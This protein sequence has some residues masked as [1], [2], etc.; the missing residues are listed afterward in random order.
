MAGAEKGGRTTLGRGAG[1]ALC[2]AD[3]AGTACCAEEEAGGL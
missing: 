1:E 3:R 2:P